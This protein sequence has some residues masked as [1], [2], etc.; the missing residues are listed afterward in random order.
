MSEQQASETAKRDFGG[1]EKW[2]EVC[3]DLGRWR[4]LDEFWRDLVLA[5][6][7]LRKSPVF[8]VVALVTLTLAIGANT[9]I[10]S[11][12][13]ELMLKALPV[14]NADRLVMLSVRPENT[15]GYSLSYPLFKEVEKQ[16][17]S[18]MQVFAF[19]DDSLTMRGPDGV[20]E[21]RAQLV[22][23]QYFSALG[24]QPKIGRWIGRGDDETGASAVVVLSDH[25]WRTR[26]NGDQR[27][28]GKSITFGHSTFTVIGVM[29][30][31]FRG[32]DK[33]HRQE[34]FI[35]L[36]LEPIADAPENDLADGN[37]MWWLQ[38]GARLNDGVSSEQAN[39]FL[40]ASSRRFWA[41][42]A[43]SAEFEFY[44]HKV[45]DFSLACES[46][47]TGYSFLRLRFKKTLLV[48]M[49]LVAIVL[50]VACLNL[51]AL[52]VAR[53]A[54]RGREFSTRFSLGASSG[55]LLRQLLTE[56][57]LLAL[58][59]ALL[60]L[61]LAPALEG[62]VTVGLNFQQDALN[63]GW[64]VAP[65]LKVFSFTATVAILVTILTG[66]FPA[67]QSA[68][69]RLH[70]T[71]RGTDRRAIWPRLLLTA[72]VALALVLMTGAS[73]LGYSLVQYHQIPIGLDPHGLV[74]LPLDMHQKAGREDCWRMFIGMWF[75]KFESCRM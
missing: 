50:V 71:L 14:S 38:A 19:P 54:S 33:D 2:K 42:A 17:A 75:Q 6:R 64:D 51:A 16:S 11:L 15:F 67:L 44:G 10:F 66:I 23:G 74:F 26:L 59:G 41:A 4:L 70:V 56:S 46:G 65:D 29:P 72:E 37:A 40:R 63:N 58:S 61:A 53:S 39:A 45:Q 21:V 32:M 47:A 73:L 8:T 68:Q 25:F 36:A 49:V 43:G 35:P 30:N 28:L 52:L 24:V 34:V 69:D 18:V 12:M 9:A 31:S 55:R 62:F 60:G 20:D 22:S 7:M 5:V 13:N 57:L 3:R 48:L 27:V 1:F